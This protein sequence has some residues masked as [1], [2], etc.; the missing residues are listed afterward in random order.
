MQTLLLAAAVLVGGSGL[1]AILLKIAI[2]CVVI[3]AVFALLAWA[4]ITIPQPVRII[5]IALA[6]IVAIIW[7]FQL[8]G[9]VI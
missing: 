1:L 4:G 3:W 7:L 9:A 8:A 6:C 5:L 2:L